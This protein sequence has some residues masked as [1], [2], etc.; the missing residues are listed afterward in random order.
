[1]HSLNLELLS[2][3]LLDANVRLEERAQQV[4][5]ANMA[6]S[7]FLANVSHELRTP[8]NAIVGYNALALSGLYGEVTPELRSAQDRIRT[9]ADH[10]SLIHISEPTRQAE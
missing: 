9:A 5:E 7:R 10:L 2:R 6:K 3:D 1:M 4:N 8:L